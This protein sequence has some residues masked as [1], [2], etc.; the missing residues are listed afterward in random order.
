MFNTDTLVPRPTLPDSL[1]FP[2]IEPVAADVQRPFWSVMIPTLNRPEFVRRAIESV[3]AEGYSPDEMQICVVD[4]F[5]TVADIGALV[6]EIGGGRVEYFRQPQFVDI[7]TSWNTCIQLSRGHYVQ[8]LHDDT[9]LLP[10]FYAAKRQLIDRGC[11]LVFSQVIGTDADLNWWAISARVPTTDGIIDNPFSII[12]TVN[13]FMGNTMIA[14]RDLYEQ[15]GGYYDGIFYGCDQEIT[16]RLIVA[17]CKN[18]KVGMLVRP[19]SLAPGHIGQSSYSF[20]TAPGFRESDLFTWEMLIS[21]HDTPAFR[22]GV[23][24]YLSAVILQVTERLTAEGHYWSA[25]RQS[26]WAYRLHPRWKTLN[27]ILRTL[28]APPLGINQKYLKIGARLRHYFRAL[29]R[30][31]ARLLNAGN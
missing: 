1:R 23:Y 16:T 3:L 12:T 9:H 7:T 5:T 27:N 22:Q 29:I 21:H 17:A 2:A 18:G 26:F 31:T 25:I 8:L 28:L 19:Y 10:G 13:A 30:R 24:A 4:N 15:I 6:E 11:P 20:W 14:S